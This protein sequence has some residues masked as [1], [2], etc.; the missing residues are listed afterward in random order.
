M[1]PVPGSVASAV[2]SRSLGVARVAVSSARDRSAAWSEVRG[3]SADQREPGLGTW[4]VDAV[5]GGGAGRGGQQP[6]LPLAGRPGVSVEYRVVSTPE[7]AARYGMQGSPTI[8]I[9][10]RDPFAE[11]GAAASLSCRLYLRPHQLPRALRRR[12]HL[13]AAAHGR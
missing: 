3:T 12:P 5:P 11:P 6:G 10:G 7:E 1:L 8:L 9:D 13:R 2:A 4:R